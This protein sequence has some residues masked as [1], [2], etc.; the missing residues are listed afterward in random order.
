MTR[1]GGVVK[2]EEVV[3]VVLPEEQHEEILAA[4]ILPRWTAGAVPQEQPVVVLVAGPAG[5]AKSTVCA[6]ITKVL[7]RRGGAV[8]VGRDLYKQDHPAYAGLLRNDDRTAGVRVR[9]DVLRWQAEVEE[10]VRSQRF[11]AVVETPRADP[12]ELRETS[13]AYRGAGYRVEVVALA[14]AQALTQLSALDRY[15]TQVLERGV[16]RYVS[17]GNFDQCARNLPAFLEVVESERLADRVLVARRDLEVLY[18][19]EL[20]EGGS[21]RSLPGA[22][23]ALLAERLRPWTAP[24]TW[25]FT[26]QLAGA[27]QRLQLAA[28]PPERS[29]LVAGGLERAF[30]LSEPV[31]RTAQP[32][33]V[34]PGIDYHRLSRDEH[35]FV[36]DELVVPMYLS[37]ITPQDDPIT[38]YVMGPQGVG[39]SHTAHALLR[40][41]H[42]RRPI[43]IEGGMFKA[44][45]PDYR[46]LLREQ[47]R[48]ASA[49]IR[50]DYR[51][52]Q[53]K[54]EAYVRERRGDLLIE[55]APDSVS[56]FLDSARRDHQAGRRVELIVLGARAADSRLGTATRCAELARLGGTPRF[57]SAAAHDATFTV[58]PDVVRAAERSPYVDSLSVIRRDLTAVYRNERP[59]GGTWV[60][61][62]RGGHAV[63]AEQQRPYT[64]AEAAHLLATLQRLQ[65]ELPQYRSDLVEIAALAWPLMPAH[66]QP[67]T[68]ATT[69]TTAPLPVRP[70][71]SGYW[72]SNS[73]ARAA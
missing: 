39:K 14:A 25:G 66:L 28:V 35:D 5:S 15:L 43:R 8:P 42:R 50:G 24:E 22:A 68:L 9:P 53:Q 37:N 7:D 36:F 4:R 10:Y 69:I 56:H 6:L 44:M 2:D 72:T 59:R 61:A 58:V 17:W 32:L 38:L 60:H 48:T 12:D 27:R 67:R 41:L 16:G 51:A 23:Q 47:P 31:R 52:W 26:R 19:N 65:G 29:M 49:R 64:P 20:T 62:P 70:T 63:E 11:D 57:T 55:I 30:A 33:T 21:W 45:H 34:P 1:V 40:A 71:A 13:R 18:V 46:Q 73:L 54:S 3:P